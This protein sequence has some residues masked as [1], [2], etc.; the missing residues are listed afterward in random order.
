MLSPWPES[1]H[2]FTE[3]DGPLLEAESMPALIIKPWLI[4]GADKDDHC[5][6]IMSNQ[7]RQMF[8]QYLNRIVSK[9]NVIH[10]QILYC[11]TDC[12]PIN[13]KFQEN[14]PTNSHVWNSLNHLI[15]HQQS[16]MI[17]VTY[18]CRT[19]TCARSGT[20]VIRRSSV[21]PR[22]W[23][24]DN[25]LIATGH[26]CEV[27]GCNTITVRGRRTHPLLIMAIQIT[28]KQE[29]SLHIFC[30]HGSHCC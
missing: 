27:K 14:F 20:S 9:P 21:L 22:A 24:A 25:Q 4:H 15:D 1:K 29:R 12:I 10:G 7:Q 6:N 23:W 5:W 11:K 2:G 17:W 13:F 18:G 26:S 3:N 19:S 30:L 16:G 8:V 28:L